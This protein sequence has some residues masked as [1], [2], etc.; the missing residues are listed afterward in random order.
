MSDG[1]NKIGVSFV[2]NMF[3]ITSSQ[4]T[5]ID[6]AGLVY[7]S[8]QSPKLIDTFNRS[9]VFFWR[10]IFPRNYGGF[11]VGSPSGRPVSSGYES[12]C[13]RYRELLDTVPLPTAEATEATP[14]RSLDCNCGVTG[15]DP[16]HREPRE[17]SMGKL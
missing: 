4:F 12:M 8:F 16:N 6:C 11:P 17:Y 13:E 10:K 15:M 3:H 5:D 7:K 2:R 9:V 14:S 1:C